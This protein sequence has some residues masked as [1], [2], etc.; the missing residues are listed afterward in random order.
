VLPYSLRT[1][2][3]FVQMLGSCGP[4]PQT[5][6]SSALQGLNMSLWTV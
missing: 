4:P 5:L 3:E 6:W 2:F 1:L